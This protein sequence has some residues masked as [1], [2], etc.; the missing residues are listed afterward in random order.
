MDTEKLRN[1]L[2]DLIDDGLELE[3]IVDV[4]R[5]LN[6]VNELTDDEYD[7]IMEN[8]NTLAKEED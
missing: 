6:S 2:L 8:W 3:N 7:Y 4:L 5:S 1:L